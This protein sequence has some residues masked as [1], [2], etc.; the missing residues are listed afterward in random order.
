V[1]EHTPDQIELLDGLRVVAREIKSFAHHIQA[2]F[3]NARYENGISITWDAGELKIGGAS[4]PGR[5]TLV[6]LERALAAWQ[7][8]APYDCEGE[9]HMVL[10][11][12]ASCL[13]CGDKASPG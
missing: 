13:I 11:G 8:T 9:G 5:L 4:V 6:Q 12:S 3:L 1:D 10:E 2:D 7:G